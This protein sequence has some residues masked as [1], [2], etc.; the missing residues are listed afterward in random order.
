MHDLGKS[1]GLEVCQERSMQQ[2]E[3]KW[4]KKGS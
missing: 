4:K 3:I 2:I 1:G